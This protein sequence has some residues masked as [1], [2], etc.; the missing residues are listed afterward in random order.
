LYK[1]DHSLTKI[2][3]FIVLT[4]SEKTSNFTDL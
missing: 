4:I 2:V 1:F 3:L